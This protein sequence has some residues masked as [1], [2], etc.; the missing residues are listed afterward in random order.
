MRTREEA[1]AACMRLAGVYEDYPLPW[2]EWD[3]QWLLQ[4]W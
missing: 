4:R 1:V 2:L 3:T